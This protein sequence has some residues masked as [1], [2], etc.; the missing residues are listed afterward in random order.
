MRRHGSPR[1]YRRVR[2]AAG[3]DAARRRGPTTRGTGNGRRGRTR[4]TAVVVGVVAVTG[5]LETARAAARLDAGVAVDGRRRRAGRGVDAEGPAAAV[6]ASR[7]LRCG[8]HQ[9]LEQRHGKGEATLP[10]PRHTPPPPL[11]RGDVP[12]IRSKTPS[13]HHVGAALESMDMKTEL[14]GDAC[15]ALSRQCRAPW[16]FNR[17]SGSAT[18]GHLG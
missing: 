4:R 12:W 9:R 3:D 13:G 10:P 7:G 6:G 2:D 18:L 8:G 11:R 17:P 14:G 5:A 15:V 1:L 16:Y